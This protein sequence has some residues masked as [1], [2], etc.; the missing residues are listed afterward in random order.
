MS[1]TDW[2]DDESFDDE[3]EGPK[4]DNEEVEGLPDEI[5]LRPRPSQDASMIEWRTW[6]DWFV[7]TAW[8]AKNRNIGETVCPCCKRK[9]VVYKQSIC[10]RETEELCKLVR[11]WLTYKTALHYENFKVKRPAEKSRQI[12]PF[13]KFKHWGFIKKGMD[14]EKGK[15]TAGWYEPE[16]DGV[17]FVKGELT[18]I[19]FCTTFK[20]RVVHWLGQRISVYDALDHHF[21]FDAFMRGDDW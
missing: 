19:K 12:G 11:H 5:E 6:I 7:D 9:V 3:E 10:S 8:M 17:A 13:Y 15:I 2:I 1:D 14:P 16:P 20:N 21:D 4:E 18:V